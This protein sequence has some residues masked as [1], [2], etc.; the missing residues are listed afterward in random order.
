[1]ETYRDS[2]LYNSCILASNLTDFMAA[3]ARNTRDTTSYDLCTQHA[4]HLTVVENTMAVLFP[5]LPVVGYAATIL[6]GMDKAVLVGDVG[7]ESVALKAEFNPAC[8]E[9]GAFFHCTGHLC[10]GRR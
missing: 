2:E 7:K 8:D 10:R 6:E 3:L 5:S 4:Q 9:G 1:M